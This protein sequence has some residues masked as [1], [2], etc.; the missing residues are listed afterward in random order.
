MAKFGLFNMGDGRASQ[1]Y[2]G[3][4]ML[5]SGENVMIYK[6]MKDTGDIQTGAIRLAPTQSVKKISD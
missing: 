3:D 5:Q 2:E 6:S 4:Y 1:E